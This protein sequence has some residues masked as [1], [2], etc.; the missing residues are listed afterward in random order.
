[1]IFLIPARAG[2]KRLPGK[3]KRLFCGLPLWMWSLATARR[4]AA[5]GDKIVLSS[6]DTEIAYQGQELVDIDWRPEHLCADDTPSIAVVSHIFAKHPQHDAL[7]LLQP[8]SPDRLDESVFQ[9]LYASSALEKSIRGGVGGVPTG[10][11]YV[12]RR[13]CLPDARWSNAG[14]VYAPASDIDTEADFL[15]AER[16]MAE[17]LHAHA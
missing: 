1:M 12:Y 4:V 15:A 5:S 9:A 11:V 6:D 8:T 17:R 2:S 14:M 13:D 3:N 16:L 10:S 7:V